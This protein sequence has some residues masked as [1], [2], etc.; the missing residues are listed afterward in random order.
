MFSATCFSAPSSRWVA[1]VPKGDEEIPHLHRFGF[2]RD[3]LSSS[4]LRER[5]RENRC[6][7]WSKL[8]SQ[9]QQQR[10]IPENVHNNC[11][12]YKK[13]HNSKYENLPRFFSICSRLFSAADDEKKNFPPTYFFSI[14]EDPV[15]IQL[16]NI[17]CSVVVVVTNCV[18]LK[19]KMNLLLRLR[20]AMSS[21]SR[22]FV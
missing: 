6:K 20:T 16:Y 9:K 5:E 22:D 11:A 8:S 17:C 3:C 19:M 12:M 1:V 7:S 14:T 18:V 15:K 21:G 10:P 4:V 2:R 13:T